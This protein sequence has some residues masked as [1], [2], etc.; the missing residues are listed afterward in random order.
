MERRDFLKASAAALAG[1]AGARAL[2]ASAATKKIEIE[3]EIE[4]EPKPIDA[5]ILS[6]AAVEHFLP[7]GRTCA[8]ALLMAGCEALGVKSELIPDIGLGL[9]GGIGLLGKTCGVV[10]GAVMVLG[11][12]VGRKEPDYA[13]RKKEVF[14]VVQGFCRSFQKESGTVEC[15]KLC[16]LD[17]TTP[18]GRKALRESVKADKCKKL[19]ERGARMLAESLL[20]LELRASPAS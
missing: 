8:E 6:K 20:R 16:G 7:G 18:E 4:P 9:G 14:Q 3:P 5:E 15:R 10:T 13:K 17:L 2:P 19:V 12:A 11:V 1:A